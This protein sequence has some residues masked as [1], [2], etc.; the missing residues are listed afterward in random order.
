M[1]YLAL[2]LHAASPTD[3]AAPPPAGLRDVRYFAQAGHSVRGSF[4]AFYRRYGDLAVFGLPLTEA[5]TDHGRVVQYFERARLELA[6]AGVREGPLGSL[7]IAG[8]AFPRAAPSP[9]AA[10]GR[11]FAATGHSLGGRFLDFWTR[12]RGQLL[13][14]A[15]ISQPLTEQNGDGTGRTYQVQYFQNARLEYHPANWR[16]PA[17]RCSSG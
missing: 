2:S 17:T 16:G 6:A 7:L 11:Y 8:R 15:P 12:H 10:A 4:Y 9:S 13:F 14:G 1:R 5:F 3:P